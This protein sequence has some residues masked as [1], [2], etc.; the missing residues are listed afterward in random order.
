MSDEKVYPSGMNSIGRWLNDGPELHD[1]LFVTGEAPPVQAGGSGST[2]KLP[3]ESSSTK[4]CDPTSFQP[5]TNTVVDVGSPWIPQES[6]LVEPLHRPFSSRDKKAVP[7]KDGLP[8][9]GAVHTPPRSIGANAIGEDTAIKSSPQSTRDYR[10]APLPRDSDDSE[11]VGILGS[12]SERPRARHQAGWYS[13]VTSW[14][15]GNYRP[16]LTATKVETRPDSE[17]SER[18]NSSPLLTAPQQIG[19]RLRGRKG[20]NKSDSEDDRRTDV[21]KK[22]KRSRYHAVKATAKDGRKREKDTTLRYACPFYQHNP[23]K[24]QYVS[25]SGKGFATIHR[26]K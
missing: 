15:T 24:N 26:L 4:N 25:C 11:R 8:S 1:R 7:I 10:G 12:V 19:K 5:V 9:S 3:Q 21:A 22:Q 23:D 20:S 18:S 13:L 6:R 17:S 16:R 14:F 2:N